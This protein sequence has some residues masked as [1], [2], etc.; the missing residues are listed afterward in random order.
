MYRELPPFPAV[1]AFEAAA[2]RLSFRRAAEELHVSD[3]A[4]S[5][6]VRRLEEFLGVQLFHREPVGVSLTGAGRD[7]LGSVSSILDRLAEATA[8]ARGSSMPTPVRLRTTPAFAARWLLPRL[9]LLQA[10]HPNLV[11]EV[12]TSV[13]AVDFRAEPVDLVVQYGVEAGERLRVAPLMTSARAPVCS[14]SLLRRGP[15]LRTPADLARHVLLRDMVGDGWEDWCR[16]AGMPVPAPGG[17]SFEH[18]ELSLRAAEE[19]QGV[20]LGY[21]ALLG[22]ELADG[23]LVQPFA[24]STEPAVIYSTVMPAGGS[25]RPD[26]RALRLWLEAQAREEQHADAPQAGAVRLAATR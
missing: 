24:L 9:R 21:L 7:Y 25:E 8:V 1:R 15:P 13:D 17:P 14:P 22:R 20:A 23:S 16:R 2:R 11:L 10:R 4:I 6:Q 3:S 18:C 19:G 26:V 12:T 5:H